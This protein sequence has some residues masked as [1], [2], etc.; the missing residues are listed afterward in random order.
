MNVSRQRST[1]YDTLSYLSHHGCVVIGG[2]GERRV[3]AIFVPFF[4]CGGGLLAGRAQSWC[5]GLW[6]IVVAGLL[7]FV[8]FVCGETQEDQFSKVSR[9]I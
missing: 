2:A 6:W 7:L 5:R 1:A 8:E 9:E 4:L 3:W